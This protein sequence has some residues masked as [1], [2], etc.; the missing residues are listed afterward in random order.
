MKKTWM[1]DTQ[2]AIWADFDG[3]YLDLDDASPEFSQKVER[4]FAKGIAPF[5]AA[6]ILLRYASFLDFLKS[7][8]GGGR[9]D[10]RKGD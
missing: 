1:R 8:N 4:L 10:T 6:K 5:K 9:Y 2:D 3:Y 7:V